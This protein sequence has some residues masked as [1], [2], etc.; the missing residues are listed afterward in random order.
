LNAWAQG[1]FA[2]RPLARS[3]RRDWEYPRL[4]AAEVLEVRTMLS[5]TLAQPIIN[6][7]PTTKDELV[8][9]PVANTTANPVTFTVQSSDSHVT[10]TIVSGGRSLDLSVSGVD[11]NHVA[12][13]GHLVFRLFESEDPVTTARIIQLANSNFYNGLTFHR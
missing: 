13:S 7:M 8:A 2:R 4:A 9:L 5:V 6:S 3:R 11:A 1:L 10:A 12:F